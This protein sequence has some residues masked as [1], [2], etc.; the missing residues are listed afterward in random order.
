MSELRSKTLKENAWNLKSLYQSKEEWEK[1]FNI[2][3]ADAKEGFCQLNSFKEKI[4]HGDPKAVK[5]LLEKYFDYARQL[6]KVYTFSHLRHDE[7]IGND[8]NKSSFDRSV[9]LYH[10][11][12]NHTSWLEPELLQL[13]EEDLR[14]LIN[15]EELK[16]YKFYLQTLFDQKEHV[17]DKKQ[18]ELLSLASKA[19]ETPQRAFSALS[20]VDMKFPDIEDS[21]GKKHKLT[22]GSY[23]KFMK[24][25]D[26]TLRE[27][28]FIKTHETFAKYE[29]T[30]TALIAGQVENHVFRMKAR[31]YNSC[32]EAAIKR[33]QIPTTVVTNLIDSTRKGIGS[34]HRYVSL[35]KKLLGYDKLNFWDLS[36]PIVKDIEMNFPYDKACEMAVDS[37][38]ILGKEYQEILQNGLTKDAWVDRFENQGKRSGAYSS[39][40]Y[41]S[42]PYILLN[43]QGMLN[44][45][46]TLVHEGGH[47][48]HSYYSN[49]SQAYHE[50][51][52]PIFVAE[53]ASTFNE[54]IASEYLIERAKTK[55]ERL[56]LL[57]H[58]ID[59]I[60][61]TFFR[62][63]MFAEFELKIH[64]LA[65]QDQPLTKDVLK[66][67]YLNLNADYFGPDLDLCDALSVEYM[68]VPHFY[69]NF[70]VYQYATGISAASALVDN[71]KK[72]GNEAYLKFLSSG[73][74]DY[75]ISIL[76][77]AGVDMTS[78]DSVESLIA[79]FDDLVTKFEKEIV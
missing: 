72:N 65:E 61:G 60:R 12:S 16:D 20:N 26:R 45:F 47:S 21:E 56:Y 25:Y 13:K 71:V 55:E 34:L 29:N 54:Q 41:D 1:E 73:G 38:S 28:A 5:I 68:R 19:Q 39:G 44:D 2:L 27:N 50:A 22:L 32:L 53:V 59:S 57:N 64:E 33:Y 70:Y 31:G 9:G 69:Y 7:D 36:V 17:L 10:A 62:Q 46:M 77:K 4:G 24:S 66:K 15:H 8:E 37:I 67:I 58:E 74:S 23:G 48:M 6:E 14:D 18:E 52:Y 3:L 79:R 63:T 42:V 43:Y 49:K 51:N 75:P 11:F 35:R 30:L 76:Q 40:C 78:S